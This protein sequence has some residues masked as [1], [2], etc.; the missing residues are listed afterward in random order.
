MGFWEAIWKSSVLGVVQGLTEFLPVSSSGHLTLLQKLLGFD[1]AGGAMTFINIMM[2]LGTLIAVVIVFWK[3]IVALFRKPFKM[4]LMLIVATIPAGII[5]LL[6]SDEIDSI[7]AGETGLLYLALCF[8][9]T[10][11]MLLVCELI[12]KR[13]K[14]PKPLGWGNTVSMGLMQAVALFPG[15]SRSGSTIVAGTVTGAKR[16]EV[17]RFSFLM[18][19]PIILGSF[20]VEVASG[21]KDVVTGQ[22]SYFSE[23]AAPE[24][25]GMVFGVVLSMVFGFIAI[26]WMMKIIQKANY[27]WFSV[28]LLCLSLGCFWLNA[29]G[30]Y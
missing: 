30:L 11:L 3:D 9:F 12:A 8:A 19:I 23:I 20:L 21:V 29:L 1:T 5:G 14:T 4:L 22:P 18:S 27:M 16:K 24:I 2:H 10:A 26:K 25:V 6:F 13:Q 15:I 17:A 28:Y 7:F